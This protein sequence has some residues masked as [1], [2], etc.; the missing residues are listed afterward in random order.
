MPP[1]KR[2]IEPSVV[3]RWVLLL[4]GG[5]TW[6]IQLE[7]KA[8]DC[9][10]AISRQEGAIAQ[11]QADRAETRERLVGLEHDTKAVLSNLEELK[12]LMKREP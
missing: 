11:L 4:L 1:I 3:T 7:H 8:D 12:T 6:A 5:I 9:L 10:R 2:W